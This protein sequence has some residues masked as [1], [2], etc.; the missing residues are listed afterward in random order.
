LGDS[1]GNAQGAAAAAEKTSVEWPL[2]GNILTPRN[3]PIGKLAESI[4]KENPDLA[5]IQAISS[6]DSTG[7]ATL[8]M[9]CVNNK[10]SFPTAAIIYFA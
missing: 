10:P 3:P 9:R 5:D 6:Y 1:Y 2:T 4:G 8:E 7:C